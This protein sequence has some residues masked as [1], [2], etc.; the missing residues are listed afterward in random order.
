MVFS[1]VT[2]SPIDGYLGHFHF[3]TLTYNAVVKAQVALC[4]DRGLHF[5][6]RVLAGGV[7]GHTV[8]AGL[9]W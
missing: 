7:P 8:S 5:S 3:G 1:L 6:E 4:V 2:L 9:T